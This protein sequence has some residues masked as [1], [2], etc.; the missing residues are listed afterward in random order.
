MSKLLF[1]N[2]L[3]FMIFEPKNKGIVIRPLEKVTK[4]A[5]G[6]DIPEEKRRIVDRPSSGVVLAKGPDC[7]WVEIGMHIYFDKYECKEIANPENNEALGALKE[8]DALGI[9][10]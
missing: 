4:T 3:T 6:L 8:E 10:K 9:L 2:V 1:P 5:S 7:L